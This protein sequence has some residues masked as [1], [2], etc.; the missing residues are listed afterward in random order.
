MK[1]QV[2]PHGGVPEAP[3][4]EML[5]RHQVVSLVLAW[6]LSGE[7][8]AEAVCRAAAMTHPTLSGRPRKIS[9]R[10]VYRWL[11]AY[12][13]H[14]AEGLRPT[15]RVRGPP[16]VVLPSELLDFITLQKELDV[17]ASLPELV[18]RARVKGILKPSQ[19]IDR[20]TLWR[21]CRRMGLC[22]QR[23]KQTRDRDTRRFAYPHRLDMVLCD[24]KHFRAGAKR[25]KRVAL[26]FLDDC[27]R[28]GLHV[29]VGTSENR[30]LFLRGLY[31]LVRLVGL[32]TILYLDHGPGFIALDT[33]EVVKNLGA[34][35][36]HGEK[37]YP[38]GHG[39]VERFNQTAKAAVLRGLDRRPD[40]DPDCGALEVRLQHYL[41]YVYNQDLH[42]SLHKKTPSQ[43][44][45]SDDRP[46]RFP[47]DDTALRRKFVVY[48]DRRVS[49]DHVVSVDSVLYEVPRGHAGQKV[50]LHRHVLDDDRLLVPHQGKLVELSPVDLAKNARSRRAKKA[51]AQQSTSDEVTHPLP[52]S[53]ADLEFERDLQPVVD[54]DGGFTNPKPTQEKP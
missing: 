38:E 29:V 52:S 5:F 28:Y 18:R 16:S 39:K 43:C 24:G 54:A 15:A 50:I 34:L 45:L 51:D 12:Q 2:P 1:H 19:A 44:F 6:M 25:A 31:E 33:V 20:T 9:P 46:L 48:F 47:D 13:E 37:A 27:T 4:S 21:A 40:V 35:L 30:M 22:V 41:R 23:R 11:A 42:E 36:I 3:C 8:R 53:A 7:V 32:M 14:G 26:F 17:H 49:S 10:T